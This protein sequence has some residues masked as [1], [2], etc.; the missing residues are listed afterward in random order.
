MTIASIF[1]AIAW[2]RMT[3]LIPIYRLE[4]AARSLAAELQKARGRA[5]AEGKCTGVAIN[6]GVKTYQFER[7]PTSDC[8]SVLAPVPGEG[9]T[10]IDDADS[11]TVVFASGS[12]PVK[13]DT[14]GTVPTPAAITLTNAANGVRTIFVQ[15][16]GRVSV[17]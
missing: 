8:T 4:G 3:T 12:S 1:L 10:K 17:Q 15:S 9:E 5:I 6:A 16:T 11:L 14:R 2:V 13:F 7:A